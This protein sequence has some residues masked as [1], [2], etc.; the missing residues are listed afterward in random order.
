MITKSKKNKKRSRLEIIF[1]AFLV[2]LI[3]LGIAFLVVSNL[4]INKR[5]QEL[6]SQIAQLEEEIKAQ[7]KQN[8]ELQAGVS[9]VSDQNYLEQEAREKLGLKKSGE[10]VVSIQ[11]VETEENNK[12]EVKKENTSLWN[13]KTWWEWIKNKLRD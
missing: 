12:E 1:P 5:R 10:E 3:I 11:K 9:Q 6:I 8:V 2:I 4:R 7:E 13:P